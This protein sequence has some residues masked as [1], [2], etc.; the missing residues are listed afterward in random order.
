MSGDQHFP[1]GGIHFEQSLQGFSFASGGFVQDEYDIFPVG[2]LLDLA[3]KD[4]CQVD[5]GDVSN[6]VVLFTTTAI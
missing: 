5:R 2:P 4:L 6:I 3:A 1:L